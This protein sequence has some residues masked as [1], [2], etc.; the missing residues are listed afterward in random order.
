MGRMYVVTIAAAAKTVSEDYFEIAPADDKPC[1][2]HAL[3]ISQY[4]DAGD[5]AE[6]LLIVSLIRGYTASGS[7]GSA[8][9]PLLLDKNDAAAGFAAEISNTTLAT[10]GTP[11]TLHS[12][13]WNV[14][15]PYVWLPTPEMRPRVSQAESRLV[16]RVSAPA[17]SITV[18]ATLYVEEL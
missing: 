10:T 11:E 13:S 6:E 5:A 7:G 1:R 14:R 12:D 2:I 18:N 16:V 9:T 3:Y 17:D 4:S 15:I 8:F